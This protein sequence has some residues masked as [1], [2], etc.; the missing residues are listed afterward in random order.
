MPISSPVTVSGLDR[1]RRLLPQ[2]RRSASFRSRRGTRAL[3]HRSVGVSGRPHLMPNVRFYIF[4][5]HLITW[6]WDPTV[7]DLRLDPE[8]RDYLD[9]KIHRD[10]GWLHQYIGELD[11]AK[12]DLAL[13][14]ELQWTLGDVVNACVAAGLPVER[15]EEHPD[16]YWDVLPNVPRKCCEGSPILFRCR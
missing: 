6:I 11:S 15:L 16:L 10:Q 7:T 9:R 13:K 5:G 1:R 14:C 3:R 2:E 4:E 12:E 8:Y